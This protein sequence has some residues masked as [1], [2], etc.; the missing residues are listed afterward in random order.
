MLL[1]SCGAGD[2]L[3]IP[4]RLAADARRALPP[5]PRGGIALIAQHL[6]DPARVERAP[7]FRPADL[8]RRRPG[9]G[10]DLTVALVVGGGATAAR[11]AL[12]R[13]R[14]V[15]GLVLRLAQA[16]AE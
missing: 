2:A 16:H 9:S 8:A 11:G 3:D 14:G 6:L 15:R 10:D 1:L 7:C 13:E 4:P 12:V 5:R